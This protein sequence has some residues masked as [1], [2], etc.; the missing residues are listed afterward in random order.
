MVAHL[1][2]ARCNRLREPGKV[3]TDGHDAYPRAIRGILGEGVA[4]RCSQ[5]LNNRLEQDHRGL[6]GRYQPMRGFGAFQS[7]A[8]FSTAHDDVGGY[9]RHSTRLHD[10]VPL[11]SS[12]SGTAPGFRRCGRCLR[13]RRQGAGRL[14]P[15][16]AALGAAAD[17]PLLPNLTQPTSRPTV[18]ERPPQ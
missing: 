2:A 6:K 13:R 7:A 14:Y 3:T 10:V 17:Y 1:S 16:R 4:H 15:V 12:G 8:R 9:F 5:Y 11:G 18:S